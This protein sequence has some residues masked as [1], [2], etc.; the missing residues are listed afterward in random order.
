MRKQILYLALCATLSLID[1][2][3]AHAQ[4]KLAIPRA[5]V[6]PQL[7]DYINRVPE[8]AGLLMNDFRQRAPQDGRAASRETSAYLSYDDHYFYAIFVAKDDPALIRARIAKREDIEGDD[9]LMLEL[10]TF[11]DKRRSFSFLVNPY[12]VQL[13]SL[14]TEG[15]DIDNS[16]DTQW[17]SEA[18]ITKDGFVAKFAIP[19][20]SLRFKASD[21]QTWGVAVGRVIA[22]LNEETYAPHISK[23][24][25]GFVPQLAS[26]HIPEKIS[27]GKNAQVTPF[28]LLAK[29]RYLDFSSQSQAGESGS[30]GGLWKSERQAQPGLDAKWVIGDASAIDLTIKPDFSEVEADEPQIVIDKRYEVLFP[31]KR[32][33]FLENAGFFATPTPLFFSRRI[34]QP[35]AGLRLTGRADDW[36][37]GAMLMRDRRFVQDEQ[38]ETRSEQKPREENGTIAVVRVQRDINEDLSVGSLLSDSR[39]GARQDRLFEIDAR[40]NIDENWAIQT[41]LAHS[42]LSQLGRRDKAQLAYIDARHQGSSLDLWLKYLDVGKN[43]A[44]RLSFLPRTEVKQLT[45]DT[46]YLWHL[47][48]EQSIQRLGV[49]VK[50]EVAYDRA[51]QL[52]DWALDTGVFLEARGNS[53]LE[54]NYRQ[55]YERFGTSDYRKQGWKIDVGTSWY[56]WLTVTAEIGAMGSLNYAALNDAPQALGRGRSANIGVIIKPHPQWRLEQ[57]MLWNDLKQPTDVQFSDQPKTIY[58]NLMWRSKFSYQHDRFLGVRL[59]AD[60]HLLDTHTQFSS[61]NAGKQLNADL[62]LNYTLGPGTSLIAG[63]GNRQENLQQEGRD[64]R[65]VQNLS[66]QTATRVFVKLNYLY[67][68]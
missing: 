55:G 21:V 14:R 59:I 18:R 3:P 34:Q 31:E 28:L 44:D 6:A 43:F 15:H 61:L 24:V 62:Q 23:Q 33:F 4:E 63:V 8:S 35:Q 2:L 19:F 10:D 66:V 25:A 27:A 30:E 54:L 20:K 41:Q 17:D 11:H 36:A 46:R 45:Q 52:Q 26:M 57:R 37:Y 7:S 40:Y 9:L 12:G 13:D 53:W 48:D 39:D 29:S 68:L 1:F 65:R 56:K 16:F 60:Y 67:Q 64:W 32:P 51:N 50:S 58:R 22:R 47:E 38:E 49:Q 42:E 5:I